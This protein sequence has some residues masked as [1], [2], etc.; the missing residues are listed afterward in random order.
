MFSPHNVLIKGPGSA[1][2]LPRAPSDNHSF[3]S[4]PRVLQTHRCYERTLLESERERWLGSDNAMLLQ[5]GTDGPAHGRCSVTWWRGWPVSPP[6][7]TP[8]P[9]STPS[10]RC[11]TR[12]SSI[13][14]TRIVTITISTVVF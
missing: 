3:M 1:S 12:V 5:R 6:P 9:A 4:N 8:P 14:L 10:G 7:G 2:W 11:R 13:H